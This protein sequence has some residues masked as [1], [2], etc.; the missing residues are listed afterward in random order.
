M[1]RNPPGFYA[2]VTL[3]NS[4]NCYHLLKSSGYKQTGLI[5]PS[6]FGDQHC[7]PHC[8]DLCANENVILCTR[9]DCSQYTRPCLPRPKINCP[10]G[11]KCS[12]GRCCDSC[13]GERCCRDIGG[14]LTQCRG[15]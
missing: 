9:L 8:E 1:S 12:D 13:P 4:Q 6:I 3:N 2:K 15:P 14:G 5:T 11:W 10:G 7:S